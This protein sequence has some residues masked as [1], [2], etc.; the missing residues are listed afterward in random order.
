MKKPRLL[1]CCRTGVLDAE[2]LPWWLD[3]YSSHVE[4]IVV[5]CVHRPQ[6]DTSAVRACTASRPKVKLGFLECEHFEDTSSMSRLQALVAEAGPHDWVIHADTD[7][8]LDT[9][10]LQERLKEADAEG[11]YWI[12]AWIVDRFATGGKIPSLI[13]G[14]SL[15]EQFPVWTSATQSLCG[16]A[17]EKCCLCVWPDIGSIHCFSADWRNAR[18]ASRQLLQHHYKWHSNLI[19]R[20]QRFLEDYQATGKPWEYW[21]ATRHRLL[22]HYE[23]NGGRIAVESH[24]W[25]NQVHGWF[26][27]STW[28]E[29]I[30]REVPE[31]GILVEAGVWQGASLIHLAQACNA[32]GKAAEIY[33]VDLFARA[34]YLGTSAPPQLARITEHGSWLHLVTANLV[35]HRVIDAVKLLQL[36][37]ARAAR[38]F[39]DGSVFCCYVDGAHDEASVMQDMQAWWPKIAPGGYLS[40]HDWNWP[41]VRRAVENFAASIGKAIMNHGPSVWIIQKEPDLS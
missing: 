18:C 39:D 40:G 22:E 21:C 33:G 25:R 36:P 3:H 14:K 37:I 32:L 26:D 7:E 12:K 34:G 5:L 11:A 2:L 35:E 1:A 6:D 31:R 41:D 15:E 38:C 30:A 17:A 23:A 29:Q 19:E 24:L 9:S 4:T 13:P 8:L 28:Y 16:A 20:T 27:F 10:D